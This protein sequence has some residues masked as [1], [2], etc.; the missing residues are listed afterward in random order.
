MALSSDYK[1]STANQQSF[2]QWNRR[3]F[4]FVCIVSMVLRAF[5]SA[6]AVGPIVFIFFS[7]AAPFVSLIVCARVISQ[8]IHGKNLQ[9][10]NQNEFASRVP[11]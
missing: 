4:W 9:T 1:I 5:F 11:V 7:S 8:I 2:F 10:K 6:F 3:L